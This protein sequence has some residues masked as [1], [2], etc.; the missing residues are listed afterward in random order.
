MDQ[1]QASRLDDQDGQDE[2]ERD[3]D[4]A[5]TETD[6]DERGG[7]RPFDNMREYAESTMQ[8]FLAMYGLAGG[9]LAK[10]VGR[11]LPPS[12]LNPAVSQHLQHQG[13]CHPL[14]FDLIHLIMYFD[15]Y[16][17]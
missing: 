8:E 1:D 6:A 15:T 9:E 12:F 4:E 13:K 5:E 3:Q 16:H 11:Q 2:D 17:G 7:G 14:V 10:S